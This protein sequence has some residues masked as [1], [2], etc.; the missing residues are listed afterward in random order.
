[1]GDT[2]GKRR[3]TRANFF[4]EGLGRAPGDLDN[5]ASPVVGIVDFNRDACLR[6]GQVD[7]AI[8]LGE[9]YYWRLQRGG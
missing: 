9:G 4:G 3:L 8:T 7:Q 1:M 5:V 2:D 6:I